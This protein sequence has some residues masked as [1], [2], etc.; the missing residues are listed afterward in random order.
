MTRQPAK[1]VVSDDQA[2]DVS[3]YG[4]RF[5]AGATI[6]PHVL[7]FVEPQ[8]ATSLGLGAG[9]RAVQSTRSSTQKKPWKQLPNMKGVVKT[10]FVRP[11][12]L[13]ESILPYRVLPAREA[14]LPL[15]H[16]ELLDGEHPHLDLYPGLNAM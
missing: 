6:F 1:L 3:P 9:R 16:N 2:A 8:P 12:L 10:Q 13:G 4:D 11:V 15:E 5:S 14:V 7:F